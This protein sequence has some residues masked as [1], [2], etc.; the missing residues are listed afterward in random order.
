MST[1][2][3]AFLVSTLYVGL[4]ATQQ[5]NVQS[6]RYALVPI[7]SMAMAVADYWTINL[8]VKTGWEVVLPVGLGGATGA[9]LAIYVN[10]RWLSKRKT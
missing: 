1:L 6:A 7:V 5:L 3:L 9:C 8:V 4:R 2:I 10:Q